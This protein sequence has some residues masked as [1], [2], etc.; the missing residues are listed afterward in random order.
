VHLNRRPIRIRAPGASYEVRVV[1]ARAQPLRDFYHALLR[2]SWGVTSA[3]VTAVFLVSNAL[4]ALAYL[5]VG[6]VAKARPGSFADA[7]FFSVQ[8]MATIGYGAMYPES[9]AANLLVVAQ[10]IVGLMLTALVTGLVFAKFSRSTARV[11][12]SRE[13][14]IGP[15]NGVPTLSFRVGNERGNRI[16]DVHIRVIMTRTERLQEGAHTSTF[17]RM[18]D[19]KLARESALSLQRSWSVQHPID[20]ASPLY[21]A[22]ADSMAKDETELAIMIVGMDDI[23]MQPVHASHRYF[24]HQVAWNARH[25]DILSESE[26][27]ALVLD[28]RK[29]HEVERVSSAPDPAEPQ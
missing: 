26:D 14:V 22:T 1:G 15:V 13:V 25:A 20:A 18:L 16:V 27:G 12:F 4:F 23:S 3:V 2:L 10:S 11:V 5:A 8:T 21:G 19:L 17:Y 28:L 29:F 9:Q 6:G 7:F 24:A